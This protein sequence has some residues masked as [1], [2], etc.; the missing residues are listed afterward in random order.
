[1]QSG[2]LL[3]DISC[4][5]LPVQVAWVKSNGLRYSNDDRKHEDPMVLSDFWPHGAVS[6]Q[7]GVFNEE[8][9]MSQRALF[10]IG[11]DGKVWHRELITER[12][13]LPDIERAIEI[14]DDV[15]MRY[16]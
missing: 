10:V 13:V 11:Q 5:P 14:A 9:G 3:F 16:A 1:M 15:A 6:R 7:Y 12:G 8:R 4:D 2:A